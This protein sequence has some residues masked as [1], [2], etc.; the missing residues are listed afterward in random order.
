MTGRIRLALNADTTP[1]WISDV[2]V[3]KSLQE[4]AREAAESGFGA[5]NVDRGENGLDPAR[6]LDILTGF[7]L[8]VASGFFH[9]RFHLVEEEKAILHAAA[10]Q[11]AFSQAIGQT[12]LFVSS[13][14]SPPERQAIAG[15]VRPGEAVS[16]Q[17]AEMT[18][19]ARCLEKV[20]RIWADHGITLC[21]H[22]H[23]ATYIEAPHEIDRLLE[24]SDPALVKLGPDTGHLFFGGSDPIRFLR[25]Y[26]DRVAAIHIKDVNARVVERARAEEFDYRRACAA[27]VWTEIGSGDI[28]FPAFFECLRKR[29]WSGWVIVETDHTQLP[30]ALESS[31]A[32]RRFLLE[33]IGL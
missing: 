19:M 32:S 33:V 18:Q 12:V 20:A 31:R 15:R 16:L 9:A 27:G 30:T 8:E 7:D 29:Q 1:L 2:L 4:R 14:V 6:V 10:E 26:L 22:P 21:Y 3:F 11:A 5:V 25:R 28:D 13:L 17:S 24:L 23:V